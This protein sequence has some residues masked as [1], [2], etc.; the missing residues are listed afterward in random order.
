MSFS[1]I[2][3]AIHFLFPVVQTTITHRIFYNFK[4]FKMI[5]SVHC[6]TQNMTFGYILEA[7]KTLYIWIIH[8]TTR[9]IPVSLYNQ[10]ECLILSVL[11]FTQ[12]L[13][14]YVCV[15]MSDF[16]CLFS[17]SSFVWLFVCPLFCFSNCIYSYFPI[18]VYLNF[19]VYL[20][21]VQFVFNF[22]CN[23]VYLILCVKCCV[24]V[25][26]CDAESQQ[27]G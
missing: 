11:L 25:S 13:S 6:S 26:V 12:T 24:N 1:D 27:L 22:V 10:N 14:L 16:L 3:P 21:G 4:C 15:C 5:G 2:G 19:C 17:V 23:C 20:C 18:L 7:T 8:M 9:N